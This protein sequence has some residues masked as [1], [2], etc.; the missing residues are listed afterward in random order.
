MIMPPVCASATLEMMTRSLPSAG[1]GGA[2]QRG[3]DISQALLASL[4]SEKMPLARGGPQR[5][6]YPSDG[7]VPARERGRFSVY[8]S[9]FTAC[10]AY[11]ETSRQCA[12]QSGC[13]PSPELV[14]RLTAVRVQ[15][16]VAGRFNNLNAD[17]ASHQLKMSPTRLAPDVLPAD[18]G[19]QLNLRQ[20][21][22]TETRPA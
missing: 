1:R 14:R 7:T 4:Q 5:S 16:E 19:Y 22:S 2:V 10:L 20:G 21:V 18:S 17:L 11:K 9:V 12:S 3:T 6:R 8:E 13:G 15:V